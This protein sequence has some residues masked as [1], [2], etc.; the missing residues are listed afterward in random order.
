MG[1][2]HLLWWGKEGPQQAAPGWGVLVEH[3]SA[4][5]RPAWGGKGKLWE[6]A[7]SCTEALARVQNP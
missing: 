2:D 6:L 5:H 1:Q 3:S 7:P 4:C